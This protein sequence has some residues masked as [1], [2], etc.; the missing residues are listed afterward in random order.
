MYAV[1]HKSKYAFNADLRDFYKL[2]YLCAQTD[3]ALPLAGLET[4]AV[5]FFE[6][7]DLPP[8][9]LG[10]TIRSDIE[11]ALTAVNNPD[12]ATFFD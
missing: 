10:R 12:A 7:D 8:L 4:S 1:R 5:G 6:L 9:S 3:S 11:L 2:Y